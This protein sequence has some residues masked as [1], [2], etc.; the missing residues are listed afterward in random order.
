VNTQQRQ[1]LF[2]I[3]VECLMAR[4]IKSYTAEVYATE[5]VVKANGTWPASEP[6]LYSRDTD[7]SVHW[8]ECEA[9]RSAPAGG[10]D[11]A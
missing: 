9:C 7:G 6:P 5:I 1:H 10:G 2:Q 8:V 4:G 3:V 11:D